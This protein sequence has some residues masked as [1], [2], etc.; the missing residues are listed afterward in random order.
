MSYYDD[1]DFADEY[2]RRDVVALDDVIRD[3]E[4]RAC[5][6]PRCGCEAVEH[7]RA[8]SSTCPRCGHDLMV[9]A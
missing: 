5:P 7:T 9:S 6:L 8:R 4:R 2:R 3:R 1:P